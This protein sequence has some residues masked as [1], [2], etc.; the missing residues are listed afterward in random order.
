M[1]RDHG[2]D[3]RTQLSLSPISLAT[4]V[5]AAGAFHR[6][7]AAG[8]A[9]PGMLAVLPGLHP[10]LWMEL[11]PSRVMDGALCLAPASPG[12]DSWHGERDGVPA[13]PLHPLNAFQPYF[14]ELFTS[15]TS[16]EGAWVSSKRGCYWRGCAWRR[17]PNAQTLEG[18][19]TRVKGEF[20][21]ISDSN[22]S[23]K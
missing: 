19:G 13:Q 3:A 2:G 11:S 7:E 20:P 16:P 5:Q 23:K 9:A 18:T 17:M 10:G 14:T 15:L 22:L 4:L 6:I 12:L 1:L 21:F 8:K